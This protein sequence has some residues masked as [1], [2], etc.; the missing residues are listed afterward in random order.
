[1]TFPVRAGMCLYIAPRNVISLPLG[2]AEFSSDIDCQTPP[3]NCTSGTGSKHARLLLFYSE[4]PDNETES[5]NISAIVTSPCELGRRMV[6]EATSVSS[7]ISG[8]YLFPVIR[9]LSPV[10]Y[11]SHVPLAAVRR[12]YLT[13][14]SPNPVSEHKRFDPS[15]LFS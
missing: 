7:P 1:M 6:A 10:V 9:C 3:A 8:N 2:C 12:D 4:R 15:W 13:P 11:I 14:Y 5:V